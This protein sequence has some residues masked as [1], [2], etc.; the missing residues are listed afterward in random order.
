[1]QTIGLFY[2]PWSAE[3]LERPPRSRPLAQYRYAVWYKSN[4]RSADYMHSLL[5]ER[6]PDAAVYDVRKDKDWQTATA[7]ADR[8]VILF[9]DA[10]GL[11]F[12]PLEREVAAHWRTWATVEAMNGRRR[13]FRLNG[14]TRLGLRLRRAI[15]WSMLGELLFLPVFVVATPV[16]LAI[17]ALRGRR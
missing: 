3:T 10:I 9:P 12:A 15:E 1:M 11:G 5:R 2:T 17:D 13:H 6:F 16:L 4:P 7:R 8:V 14:A